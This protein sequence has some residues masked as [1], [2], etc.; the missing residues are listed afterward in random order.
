VLKLE[1]PLKHLARNQHEERATV[2]RGSRFF[3]FL[4]PALDDLPPS[5]VAVDADLASPS[6]GAGAGVAEDLMVAVPG[7]SATA[8]DT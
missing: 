8:S 7:V 5:S 4:T 3:F 6:W 2:E 1:E